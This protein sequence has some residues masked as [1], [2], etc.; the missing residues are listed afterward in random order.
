MPRDDWDNPPTAQELAARGASPQ[1]SF[2][3]QPAVTCPACG[4]KMFIYKTTALD[5]RVVR[6]EECRNKKC[7]KRFL[8][9]QPHREIIREIVS[10][11][12]DSSA[13]IR[14]LHVIRESA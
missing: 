5:T 9:K 13:G 14:Q 3:G 12:E 1:G 4:C 6:Y 11:D 7:R 10:D 2:S 8:T